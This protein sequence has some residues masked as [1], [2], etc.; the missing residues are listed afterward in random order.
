MH[1]ASFVE[2]ISMTKATDRFTAMM[3]ADETHDGV[4]AQTEHQTFLATVSVACGDGEM[5]MQ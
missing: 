4:S 5:G 3:I 2:V 1:S